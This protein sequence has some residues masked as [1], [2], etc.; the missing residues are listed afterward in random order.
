MVTLTSRKDI[1]ST[2]KIIGSELAKMQQAF[3]DEE[4]SQLYKNDN[5]EE[6]YRER[7]DCIQNE[8]VNYNTFNKIIG[9]KHH[10]INTYTT[11]LSIKLSDLFKV[12]GAEQI[13][14]ISHLKI[15]FFGNRDNTFELLESAYSRLEAIVADDTFKEAFV[16]D[17][18]SLPDFINIL[19]WIIRFDPVAAE[20]IFLFDDKEQ[21]EISLCKYGNGHLTEF[22]EE[23]L[24]ED[25]LVDL[26]WTIIKGE[27]HDNFTGDGKIEG[28]QIKM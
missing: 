19:F 15:D 28:R 9:L 11:E 7:F 10:D 14:I 4:V 21:V 20:Y 3:F 13:I 5:E 26:G 8:I 16:I 12:I 24:T 22:N 17:I 18:K 25:K 2:K 6:L 1:S 27:E 23:R